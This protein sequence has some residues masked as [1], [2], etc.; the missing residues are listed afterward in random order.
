VNISERVIV[1]APLIVSQMC[2]DAFVRITK[3]ETGVTDCT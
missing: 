3:P 2:L 1:F